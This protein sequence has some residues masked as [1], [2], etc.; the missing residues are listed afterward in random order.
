MGQSS[1]VIPARLPIHALRPSQAASLAT[2]MLTHIP[3]LRSFALQLC[4][5]PD[6]ADDLVQ[7]ALCRALGHL[8]SFTPGTRLRSWLFTILR[9][10]FY[11]GLR[12]SR[13]EVADPEGLLAARLAV[14]PAHD[15][16]LAMAQFLRVFAALSVEHRQVL[17]LVGAMGLTYDE[18]AMATRLKPGTVKSRVSRARAMLGENPWPQADGATIFVLNQASAAP[19]RR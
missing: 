3:A 13:R 19:S 15:G 7:D 4:R 2:E 12:K 9:N 18:A 14:A 10:G 1:A 8:D 16:A 11:S 6:Q 17:T 5:N